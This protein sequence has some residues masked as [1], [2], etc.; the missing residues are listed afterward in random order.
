MEIGKVYGGVEAAARSEDD[1][2]VWRWQQ[3]LEAAARSGSG[4]RSKV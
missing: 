1:S 3:G 2:K 4:G